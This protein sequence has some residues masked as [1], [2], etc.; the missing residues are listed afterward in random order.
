VL[1]TVASAKTYL[2]I[3]AADTTYDDIIEDMILAV[4][5]IFDN[6]LNRKLQSATYTVYMDGTGTQSIF[7]PSYPIT[8][9]TSINIDADRVFGSGTLVSSSDYVFY[10]T[11]GEIRMFKSEYPVR[12]NYF[13]SG[14]QNIKVVYVGGYLTSGTTITLPYDLIKAAKDQ[15]KFLFKKWQA[16]EEGLTSYS[17]LNSNVNLVEATDILPMVNRVLDKYRNYYHA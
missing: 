2:G 17:S 12:Y 3:A 8:S 14:S 15:V 16:G 10:E 6:E 9:I 11:T 13:P 4:G 1:I 7:V 5:D